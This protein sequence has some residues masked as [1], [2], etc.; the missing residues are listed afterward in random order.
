MDFFQNATD[1]QIALMGCFVALV[2]SAALM[3]VSVFLNR[4]HRKTQIRRDA[5]H[6]FSVSARE[7]TQSVESKTRKVA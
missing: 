6:T 7:A 1:D 2:T 3:Y 5:G 4:T